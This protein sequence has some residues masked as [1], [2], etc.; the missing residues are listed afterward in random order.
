VATAK[1]KSKA[2]DVSLEGVLDAADVLLA[3]SPLTIT[4]M[5]FLGMH[6]LQACC[7]DAGINTRVFYSN[8]PY[9][10]LIGGDLHTSWVNVFFRL[11]HS[12]IPRLPLT[13]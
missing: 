2:D 5:P 7:R 6:L 11:R 1:T 13:G 12:A 8:L 10:N 9:S 4:N 3:V